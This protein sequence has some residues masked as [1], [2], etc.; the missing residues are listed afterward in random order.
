MPMTPS[1]APTIVWFRRDLR[2]ADNAALAAAV[3]CG[4]PVICLYLREPGDPHAGALGAAQAWWLHGTLRALDQLLR[5]RGNRLLLMTGDPR[6]ALPRLIEETGAKVVYW[7]RRY[8]PADCAADAEVKSLLRGSGIEVTSFAGALLHEPS[9]LRT[10]Q[11]KP[12][13]VFTPFWR[14]L[15]AAPD[16]PAAIPC[17]DVIPAPPQDLQGES[18]DDWQLK[19]TRPDWAAGFDLHWQAGEAGARALL[20][21]FLSDGTGYGTRRD[22]PADTAISRLSPHLALGTITPGAIWRAVERSALPE[23]DQL[24]FLR[25]VAWRDFAAHVHFH[26]PDLTTVNMDRRFDAFPWRDDE[27]AF[28]AWSRGKTGY[29]LV[30]AGM[31][32][33]WQT[34]FMHNRVRMVTASFLIKHLMIDWRRGEAWFR[35]TLLDADAAS[36][37][38]NWQWVA[39]CGPDAAPYFRIFNPVLQG[40]KFDTAG[41]YI[42]RYCPELARLPDALIHKPFAARPAQLADAGVKLGTTYPL[43]IVDHAAAR[44]RA[45]AA[46]EGLTTAAR[47]QMDSSDGC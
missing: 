8:T 15:S 35:D 39:G 34:G 13:G 28:R 45:L 24:S 1:P 37:A 12:Y 31:R 20:D 14:A 43:P 2:L 18:L 23:A 25:E 5:A 7:N 6:L 46:F 17:P 36:N 10:Q 4:E 3:A 30:D 22:L 38:M 40:E 9:L 42:R 19:P 11:G 16:L 33:L 27:A 41:A 29:P 26:H 47:H 32:E 44:A 21:A